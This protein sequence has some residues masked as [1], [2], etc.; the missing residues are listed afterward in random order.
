MKQGTGKGQRKCGRKGYAFFVLPEK[1]KQKNIS[2]ENV[3]PSKIGKIM[4]IR[5]QRVL[6]IIYLA[7][8]LSKLGAFIVKLHIKIHQTNEKAICPIDYL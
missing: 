8:G 6:G 3:R 4:Q 7:R 1:W 2:F 5:W